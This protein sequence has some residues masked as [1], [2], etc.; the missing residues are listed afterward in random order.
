MSDTVPKRGAL[1]CFHCGAEPG[2]VYHTDT[3]QAERIVFD[4]TPDGAGHVYRPLAVICCSAE[5]L[6][7]FLQGEVETG[8][9]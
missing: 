3:W 9:P 7:A 4:S 8:A 5:C 6:I 2:S 1:T